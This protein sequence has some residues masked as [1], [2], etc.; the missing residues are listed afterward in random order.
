MVVNKLQYIKFRDTSIYFYMFSF[1]CVTVFF[2]FYLYANKNNRSCQ[3]GST[4]FCNTE[5]TYPLAQS[6]SGQQYN[7]ITFL[8][9]N[10]V[11]NV[12][13][14]IQFPYQS[15]NNTAY[16]NLN[17]YF[18]TSGGPT[19]D[20][21][22]GG[23]GVSF[24]GSQGASLYFKNPPTVLAPQLA[25]W[26]NFI[27]T[28]ASPNFIV[29]QPVKQVNNNIIEY[30]YVNES[31]GNGIT[32]VSNVSNFISVD[33]L[34]TD[35]SDPLS[36]NW[37]NL[38]KNNKKQHQY[39][40]S[41]GNLSN[42]ACIDPSFIT[43]KLCDNYILNESSGLYC[44]PNNL[45][46][47]ICT[48]SDT[49]GNCG[50]RFCSP[51]NNTSDS[52]VYNNLNQ[53]GSYQNTFVPGFKNNDSKYYKKGIDGSLLTDILGITVGSNFSPSSDF[54]KYTTLQNN[55]FCGGSTG[56]AT[57][58]FDDQPITTGKVDISNGGITPLY[59]Q[60]PIWNSSNNFDF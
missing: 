54:G 55:I 45:N 10:P 12:E 59:S 26:T 53:L 60:Y 21:L 11:G 44:P 22:S 34:T 28:N 9:F 17:Y 19:V 5:Q 4:L 38:L 13:K 2:I 39:G 25:H 20:V 14:T 8:T 18:G 43:S 27:L 46:C 52:D 29:N 50:Y 33:L 41:S 37:M 7:K 51:S 6:S 49:S 40:C 57:N 1:F 23:V 48:P 30:T 47:S 32:E 36:D 24:N 56:P 58:N 16:Y 42:C 31:N 3:Y 15:S 35:S